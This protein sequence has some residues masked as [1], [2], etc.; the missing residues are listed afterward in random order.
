M[1]ERGKERREKGDMSSSFLSKLVINKL[2]VT[3][4]SM[5]KDPRRGNPYVY[6]GLELSLDSCDVF[7]RR[8]GNWSYDVFDHGGAWR[9]GS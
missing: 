2:F 6:L 8:L 3:N 4:W 5:V 9:M 7:Y 1:R